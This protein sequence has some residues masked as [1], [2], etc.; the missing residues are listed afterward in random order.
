M[1]EQDIQP[2]PASSVEG[3]VTTPVVAGE[4]AALEGAT[5]ERGVVRSVPKMGTFMLIGGIAGALAAVALTYGVPS[6]PTA[7]GGHAYSSEQVLGFLAVFLIPIGIGIGGLIGS[8]LGRRSGTEV[9]M[10]RLPAEPMPEGEELDGDAEA[11]A[12]A[13]TA[14]TLDRKPKYAPPSDVDP[15]APAR[16]RRK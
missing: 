11:P 7:P 16:R 3:D 1:P 2:T 15:S 8:L 10:L 5:E 4:T 12:E 13:A 14:E 9:T 6:H